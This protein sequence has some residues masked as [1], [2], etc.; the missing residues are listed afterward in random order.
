MAPIEIFCFTFYQPTRA[1]APAQWRIS[2]PIRPQSPMFPSDAC[3]WCRSNASLLITA[4]LFAAACCCL[5]WCKPLHH[6]L[7]WQNIDA[8]QLVFFLT[9]KVVRSTRLMIPTFIN[10]QINCRFLFALST[11]WQKLIRL[12]VTGCCHHIAMCIAITI[13]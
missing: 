3:D 4:L 10:T 13:S 11:Q 2:A 8:A 6:T 7:Q 9:W 5:P 12:Y 1:H